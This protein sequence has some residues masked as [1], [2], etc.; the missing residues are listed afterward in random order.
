M[1]DTAP[2]LALFAMAALA[3]LAL[4]FVSF[5]LSSVREREKRAALF[6]GA[7]SFF[8]LLAAA[9]I[10]ALHTAGFLATPIG[11]ALLALGVAAGIAV[12]VGLTTRIGANPRARRGTRGLVTGEV[13]RYDE[14]DTV[15]SRNALQPGSDNYREYY[16]RHPEHEEYDT[17]RRRNGAQIGLRPGKLDHPNQQPFVERIT[18]DVL[19]PFALMEPEKYRP[20]VRSDSPPESFSPGEATRKVKTRSRALGACLV[21]ICEIDTLWLYTH[22]GREDKP[23]WG[24]PIDAGLAYAVVFATEMVYDMVATAPH[25]STTVETMYNYRRGAEIASALAAYIASLGY[26]AI[27]EHVTHYDAP[28]VPLAV[29]AGLGE[30]GRHGYLV[31]REYGS[32][33]RLAAVFTDLPLVADPPVDIGVWDFC[34]VCKKCATTCPSRSIPLGEPAEANGILRWKLNEQTCF[35]YWGKLGSDCNICMR[36]CPWSHAP[37]LPHRLVRGLCSRNALS[38]RL[39]TFM[40]DLFYGKK[41]KPRPL[42]TGGEFDRWKK[43]RDPGDDPGAPVVGPDGEGEDRRGF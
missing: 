22:R 8:S 24:E 31:T 28:L 4:F 9:A 38:R 15:F 35:D 21:G 20:P 33:V 17:R 11:F 13:T 12:A 26:P 14:R 42:L 25:I 40:D 3:A 19:P 16:A 34:A 37:T 41:P 32:R 1:I 18:V 2:Y 30:L 7:L 23:N 10:A 5:A 39:F 6:A 29:D 27:A 43:E 36:V